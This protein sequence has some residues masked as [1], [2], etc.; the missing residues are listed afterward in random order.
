MRNTAATLKAPCK[1]NLTLEIVDRLP[2]GYHEIRS[3]FLPV[4]HPHDTLIIAPAK[5]FRLDCPGHETLEGPDNLVT[6]AW[7]AYGNRTGFFPPVTVSL[8]KRIPMG[9]GLGGGST[10]A[11]ALLRWLNEQCKTPLSRNELHTIATGLGADVPFFLDGVPALAKGIGEQ[12]TPMDISLTG[13]HLLVA[14]PGVH[15]QT[16]W[17]YAQWDRLCLPE[18]RKLHE[19][20]TSRNLNTKNSV[21]TGRLLVGNDFESAIFGKY[22]TIRKLKELFIK[23]GA[24]ATAMSG[25]GSSVFALFRSQRIMDSAARKARDFGCD[26]WENS[27]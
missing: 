17:A 22:V 21:P 4:E 14:N 11:A 13:L 26:V 1:I 12:L 9:A 10:D 2:T 20:L 16:P 6:K 7:Q 5:A 15:V 19:S 8:H 3:V 23:N 18:K 24:A 25:S 27:F